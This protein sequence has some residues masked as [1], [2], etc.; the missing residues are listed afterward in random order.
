M[1]TSRVAAAAAL[2]GVLSAAPASALTTV[3]VS[4]TVLDGVFAGTTGS[5]TVSFDETLLTPGVDFVFS[6]E[7]DPL[8][9]ITFT[10]FSQTFDETDDVDFP[11]FAQLQVD[12][13]GTPDFLDFIVS[14]EFFFSNTTD[15]LFPGVFNIGF[16]DLT[17]D[18]SGGFITEIFVN[19]TQVV[20]LPATLPLLLGALGGAAMFARRRA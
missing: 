19:N 10:I 3:N 12:S 7:N 4:G 16:G 8:F 1:F 20:P 11:E 9:D 17:P 6:P 14:E 5:G 15:I 18:G 2:A 13:G